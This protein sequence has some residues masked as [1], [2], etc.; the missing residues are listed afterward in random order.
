MRLPNKLLEEGFVARV[1]CPSQPFDPE[2]CDTGSVVPIIDIV[3]DDDLTM[4]IVAASP[5]ALRRALDTLLIALIELFT[6]LGLVINWNDGNTEV[7]LK[8]R[9]SGSVDEYEKLRY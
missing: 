7:M 4:L 3:C 9:G 6:P 5:A 2:S 8:F 1:V